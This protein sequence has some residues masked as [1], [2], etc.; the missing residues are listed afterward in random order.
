ML[1]R[2]ACHFVEKVRHAQMVGADAVVVVN[3]IEGN[4]LPLMADDGS[5]G[6]C[7]CGCDCYPPPTPP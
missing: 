7:G 6:A 1:D 3:N 5:A 4:N 2:G